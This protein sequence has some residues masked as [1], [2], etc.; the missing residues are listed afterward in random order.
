MVPVVSYT[1]YVMREKYALTC[2][3]NISLSIRGVIWTRETKM[4]TEDTGEGLQTNNIAYGKGSALINAQR[5]DLI[6]KCKDKSPRI[7][8]LG[9]G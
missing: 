7:L 5:R 2:L 8:N 6:W 9:T 4:E 3:Q 1:Q